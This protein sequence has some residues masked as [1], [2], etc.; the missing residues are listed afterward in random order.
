[1]NSGVIPSRRL[2]A[3]RNF[4]SGKRYLVDY[5][6]IRIAEVVIFPLEAMQIT[7]KHNVIVAYKNNSCFCITA[8]LHF[9]R[10][11]LDTGESKFRD[12]WFRIR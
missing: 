1:M 12:S 10:S 11:I 8:D 9:F 5:R 6:V 2:G 7:R 3:R 4:T